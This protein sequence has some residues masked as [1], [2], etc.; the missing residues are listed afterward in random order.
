MGVATE[1]I[2]APMAR[3]AAGVRFGD[4]S[5]EAVHEIKRF[6]LDSVGCAFGGYLQHDVRILLD[7]LE[8]TAVPGP[9]T[10]IGHGRDIEDHG[11]GIFCDR[12]VAC[13]LK[14]NRLAI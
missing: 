2:T 3:W 11:F 7:V 14:F 8:E 5:K 4:L 6:L 1:N 9:A 10:L 13:D 12:Q